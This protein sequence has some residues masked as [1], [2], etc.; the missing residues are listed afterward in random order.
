VLV[1]G[2][3]AAD[4]RVVFYST[5]PA[6]PDL[7]TPTPA[8]TTDANGEF[9]LESFEAGDGAPIGEYTVTIVWPET[10]P[11]NFRGIFEAKD[12]LGGRYTSPESSKLTAKVE[13]GGG[14]IPPFALK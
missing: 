5:A 9:R 8:G 12:R 3:P 14:E 1:D 7:K 13:K 11:P 10:P 6:G 4:A 2:Q